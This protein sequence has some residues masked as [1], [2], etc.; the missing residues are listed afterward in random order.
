MPSSPIA[1][2]DSNAFSE[3]PTRQVALARIRTERWWQDRYDEIVDRGYELRHSPPPGR[4]YPK[5]QPSCLCNNDSHTAEDD[6][7]NVVRLTVIIFFS[8]AYGHH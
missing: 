7:V 2:D 8:S 4:C 1:E 3:P 6:Q 5:W